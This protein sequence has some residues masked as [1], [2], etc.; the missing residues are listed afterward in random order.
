MVEGAQDSTKLFRRK[1]SL[2]SGTPFTILLRKMV[3]LRRFAREERSNIHAGSERVVLDE[4]AAR[5]DFVAH[6]LVED[7]VGLVDLLDADL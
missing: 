5:F 7:G 1:Q 2:V 4:F 3:P 6:Q